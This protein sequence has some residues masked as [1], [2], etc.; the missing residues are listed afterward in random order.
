MNHPAW[1]TLDLA[2]GVLREP[3]PEPGRLVL[4][5]PGPAAAGLRPWER[6]GTVPGAAV[7]PQDGL[8]ATAATAV[9]ARQRLGGWLATLLGRWR[10]PTASP[11]WL[12]PDGQRVEQVGERQTDLLLVW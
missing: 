6:L 10:R 2:A 3:V 1:D 9:A 7:Q 4:W 12:L 11:T 8:C 5:L